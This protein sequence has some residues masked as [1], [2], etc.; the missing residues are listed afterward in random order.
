MLFFGLLPN[1]A[2]NPADGNAWARTFALEHR[3]FN[4]YTWGLGAA[5]WLLALLGLLASRRRQRWVWAVIGALGCLFALNCGLNGLLYFTI[6][7]FA[8][9]QGIARCLQLSALAVCVLAA[10]GAEA[11]FCAEAE[12][13]R[14]LLRATGLAA[15]VLAVLAALAL[16]GTKAVLGTPR[17]S[18]IAGPGY[19]Y[20]QWQV[21]LFLAVLVVAAGLAY[22]ALQPRLRTPALAGLAV[23]IA[24]QGGAFLRQCLSTG[25]PEYLDLPT[26]T[27]PALR[28]GDQPHRFLSL[29]VRA[30]LRLEQ[31]TPR[32][33]AW[34][35][36]RA[37]TAWS[38]RA[39]TTCSRPSARPS[40][41]CS[42]PTG[43]CPRWTC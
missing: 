4:E 31:I 15:V 1:L 11:L 29:G 41:A 39:R 6:P 3:E 13:R 32:A 14:Q 8:K 34:R 9:L 19:D 36:S 27:I 37:T 18:R 33:S 43:A 30:S 38:C 10:F 5:V 25:S 42:S 16:L 2:G 12:K 28:E 23:V 7:S 17:F 20:A 24:L 21:I 40:W 26:K 22:L 35:T